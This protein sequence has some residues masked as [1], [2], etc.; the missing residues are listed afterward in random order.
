MVSDRS[1][2]PG[3]AITLAWVAQDGPF[4]SEEYLDV[5]PARFLS[6]QEAIENAGRQGLAISDLSFESRQIHRTRPLA[7]FEEP[8]FLL[9]S[10]GLCVIDDTDSMKFE[11]INS[12]K[13]WRRYVTKNGRV[14]GETLVP[15]SGIFTSSYE[16]GF[17]LSTRYEGRH[18]DS[19]RHL[20][21]DPK[22]KEIA[23]VCYNGWCQD[24]RDFFALNNGAGQRQ[25]CFTIYADKGPTEKQLISYRPVRYSSDGSLTSALGP[26]HIFDLTA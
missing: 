23:I 10:T 1:A 22:K 20:V 19:E 2:E 24:S 25:L 13:Y 18:G 5:V 21:F 14:V 9:T 11:I 8:D 15:E 7:S 12:R 17:P 3:V 26:R 4:V 16:N 6:Q